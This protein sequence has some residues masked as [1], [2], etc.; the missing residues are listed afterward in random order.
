MNETN[1]TQLNQALGGIYVSINYIIATITAIIVIIMLIGTIINKKAH[2]YTKTIHIQFFISALLSC[3]YHFLN[4]KSVPCRT[5]LPL[6]IFTTFPI[7]SQLTCMV[8]FSYLMFKEEY[9]TTK[10]KIYIIAFTFV[11]WI[12]AIG[13]AIV[14]KEK[15]YI[16][17]FFFCRFKRGFAFYNS[18]WIITA[19][20][21][22]FFYVLIFC[23]DRKLRELKLTLTKESDV[24]AK[25]HKKLCIQFV[26]G[27]VYSSIIWF[28]VFSKSLDKDFEE[29]K[30]EKI[31]DAPYYLPGILYNLS[32]PV[33]C[34]LFIWSTNLRDS[35]MEIPCIR[36]L[37]ERLGLSGR[38][39]DIT[40]M[41]ADE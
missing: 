24:L 27:L 32:V 30:D 16:E 23:L 28:Y 31:T 19:V 7:V 5:V 18:F 37:A 6:E 8:L 41:R 35:I 1:R 11:H 38:T 15:H 26:C 12:P 39:N 10:A 13:L 36:C 22:I 29:K 25:V 20:F 3:A 4:V 40:L 33:I 17:K 21:Q 14:F 34:F 9:D 2:C